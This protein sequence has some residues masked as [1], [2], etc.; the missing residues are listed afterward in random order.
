MSAERQ[1]LAARLRTII[2]QPFTA[3]FYS[4]I[5]ER[6]EAEAIHAALTD[7]TARRLLGELLTDDA[8]CDYMAIWGHPDGFCTKHRYPRPC[9]HERAKALIESDVSATDLGKTEKSGA[10][11]PNQRLEPGLKGEGSTGGAT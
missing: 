7:D 8:A 11:L 2:D 9:P 5:V 6:S 4:V 10:S 3:G 1:A